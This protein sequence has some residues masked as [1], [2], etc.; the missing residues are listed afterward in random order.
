[1][2]PELI[3]ATSAAVIAAF[4]AAANII[5]TVL[6][7][8]H[9]KNSVLPILDFPC[10]CS[11]HTM[12]VKIK[13]AGTG[14]MIVRSLEILKDGK[15]Q[16]SL[17]PCFESEDMKY[18]E[19]YYS[20]NYGFILPD[21]VFTSNED[22]SLLYLTLREG[23]DIKELRR[24]NCFCQTVTRIVDTFRKIYIVVEYEDVYKTKFTRGLDLSTRFSKHKDLLLTA[25]SN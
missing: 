2:N 15:M 10:C 11:S 14:P 18:I 23:V 3:I 20:T 9:N 7:Q 16:N 17:R 4:A 1:M 19:P 13:N 22:F 12:S 6:Q 25:S 5:S 8:Q 21:G 24:D